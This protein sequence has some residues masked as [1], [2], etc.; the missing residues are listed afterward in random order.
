MLN[1]PPTN[2]SLTSGQESLF[3]NWLNHITRIPSLG[4]AILASVPPQMRT[5]GGHVITHSN[6]SVSPRV[7]RATCLLLPPLILARLLAANVTV[8]F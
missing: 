7:A 6:E 3:R 5:P 1:S 4:S 2:P 8:V